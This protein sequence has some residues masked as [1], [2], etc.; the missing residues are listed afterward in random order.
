MKEIVGFIIFQLLDKAPVFLGLIAMIGLILQGK[1]TSE[2]ID[3][4]VKTIIG[5]LV[6]TVGSGTLLK[7]L[8]PV[9][10]N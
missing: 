8:T 9:M 10:E 4:T 6:I 1:K 7:S 2:V 5:L 3:G